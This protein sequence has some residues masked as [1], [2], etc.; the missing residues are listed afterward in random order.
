M[1][2]NMYVLRMKKRATDLGEHRLALV[3]YVLRDYVKHY[4]VGSYI[5]ILSQLIVFAIHT[6]MFKHIKQHI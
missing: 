1:S 2:V 6:E 3:V 5:G 4:V